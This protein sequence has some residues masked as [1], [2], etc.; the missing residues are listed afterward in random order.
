LGKERFRAVPVM[1]RRALRN[2][3]RH[4][5][6]IYAAAMAYRGLFGLFP[7]V[8]LVVGLLGAL[9]FDGFFARLLEQAEAGP[10][11]P[12]PEY[13]KPAAE[14][15]QAQAEFLQNLIV[16][17]RER[18]G[19]GLISFGVAVALW[20]TSTLAR[21][22]AEALNTAYGVAETRPGWKRLLLS[23]AFG[24]ALA[25]VTILATVLMLFGSRAAEWIADLAGLGAVF[26]AL[27]AWLRLPV[28]LLLLAAVL[29]VIYRFVPDVVQPLRIVSAGAVVA[30]VLW[31]LASAGF[32]IYLANFADFGV[33]YGSL[34][35]A[36]GLLLYLYLSAS[37]VLLGA[38]VN[39][40][41]YRH[42]S[43]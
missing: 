35:A 16:Q 12:L 11:Q 29:A 7:F 14:Q 4:R 30:V 41:I 9:H 3:F 13:L 42:S 38:E 21:T 8:L 40:A 1:G 34:G 43:R 17:A 15:G 28:A 18:A 37:A 10:P 32:S 5:M 33:T 2:F 36:I 19:S 24:P 6:T 20:S 27:W 25:L 22:L 26:V 23:L 31:A 39:A